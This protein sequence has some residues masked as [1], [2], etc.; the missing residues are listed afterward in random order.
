MAGD[1]VPQASGQHGAVAVLVLRDERAHAVTESAICAERGQRLVSLGSTELRYD[2]T[3]G[4]SATNLALFPAREWTRMLVRC[5]RRGGR[6]WMVGGDA[7]GLPGLRRE[8]ATHV[9]LSRCHR[10]RRPGRGLVLNYGAADPASL[11]NA[12]A[13][14]AP[15]LRRV[16]RASAAAHSV[17]ARAIAK[18]P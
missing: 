18:R 6:E 1:L 14:A 11:S 4:P 8:I 10:A 15:A 13:L 9:G 17:V 5:A 7:Q 12:V 16:A 3:S 2:E